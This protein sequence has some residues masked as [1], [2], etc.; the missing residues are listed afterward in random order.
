[1]TQKR[2]RVRAAP[3]PTGFIHVGNLR[4]FI[5]DDFLAK[6]SGG[7]FVLRIEDT[8]QERF[9]PGAIEKLILTLK[10]M[11]IE[12]NEGVWLADDD[13][14]IVQRGDHGPYIQSERK[15]RHQ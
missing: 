7:D 1:M 4:T 2:V 11:G 8:D 10:R 13:K 5:Y 14:T 12:P 3:S 15:T 9:V 6:Q